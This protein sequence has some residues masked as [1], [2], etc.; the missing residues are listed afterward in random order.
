MTLTTLLCAFF[1]QYPQL[2]ASILSALRCRALGEHASWLEADYSVS[3]LS[4]RYLTFRWVATVLVV[5]V[6]VGIP[7]GLLVGLLLQ[8]R[9]STEQWHEQEEH[10]KRALVLP[11]SADAPPLVAQF[12]QS[13]KDFAQAAAIGS[14]G[15][16][17]GD[18]RPECFWF[19]PM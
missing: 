17:V 3:C 2:S 19:E 12:G 18:Y 16:L 1:L 8:R 4:E 11:T 5:V 15:F 9:Q 14:F 10:S 6:P 13:R 7:V